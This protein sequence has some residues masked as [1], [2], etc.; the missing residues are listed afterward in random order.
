[1]WEALLVS[2]IFVSIACYVVRTIPFI[3]REGR[4]LYLRHLRLM[5]T[6]EFMMWISWAITFLI[7]QDTL[8]ILLPVAVFAGLSVCSV[9][10][11]LVATAFR[12]LRGFRDPG[13]LVASGVY[14]I[15]RHPM[16]LGWILVLIGFP[17]AFRAAWGLATS[18]C[19]SV[20]VFIWAYAEEMEL[21]LRYG[22][23]YLAYKEQVGMFI[24][25]SW[26]ITRNETHS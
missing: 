8:P 21:G 25:R 9:G 13:K 16:Y 15:V 6:V 12:K 3:I 26:N 14:G 5:T 17:M 20:V 10:M 4:K 2:W 22:D 11:F 24:P 23:E 18:V 19:L 7:P 1:M